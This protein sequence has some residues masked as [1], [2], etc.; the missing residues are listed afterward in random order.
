MALEKYAV[1][2]ITPNSVVSW[3]P[4]LRP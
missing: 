3:G 2:A 4:A 1:I